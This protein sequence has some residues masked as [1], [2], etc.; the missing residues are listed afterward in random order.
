MTDKNLNESVYKFILDQILSNKYKPGD[1]IQ[2]AKLAADF[3]T[4]RT[5]I[6]EALRSLADDGIITIYPKRVAEV[7]Q[8][9]EETMRQIGLVRIHLDILAARLAVHNGS[10]ADFEQM[11]EHS[12]LCL[13]AA[14]ANDTARRI[15]ED[16]AFHC[17]LSR[18]S[19]N[20]QLHE[21]CSN[22]YLKIEFIQSW[23]PAFLLVP[24]EQHRQHEEI[25]KALLNRDE[26]TVS[27]LIIRHHVHFHNLE[28]YYPFNWLYKASYHNH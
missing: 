9:D 25:Y 24:A 6:R 15:R 13:E 22:L 1:K 7:A 28:E 2:E 5:P 8:M 11:F 20:R 4:S 23:R 26:K 14:N 12:K 18:I 21:F 3:G 10:N 19:K 27:E 17:E 16:C